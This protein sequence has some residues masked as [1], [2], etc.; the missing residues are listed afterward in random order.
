MRLSPGVGGTL[1][2][3]NCFLAVNEFLPFEVTRQLWLP[4]VH[5]PTAGDP[6]QPRIR[7]TR[8][9]RRAS[10]MLEFPHLCASALIV[11]SVNWCALTNRVLTLQEKMEEMHQ[12]K[13]AQ[14]IKSAEGSAGLLHKITKPT[15]W[16][17]QTQMLKKEEEDARLWDCCEAKREAWA[18]HWQCDESV[19]NVEDKPRE[20][21]ELKRLEEALPRLKGCDLEQVSRLYKAKTG[22]G[23]D[24]FHP[25]VPGF[26]KRN[27]RRSGG[28]LGGGTKWKMG[29]TKLAQR[30]SS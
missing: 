1:T 4:T 25:K 3:M 7:L 12:H 30:F 11:V 18:K 17:G 13:V 10:W 23:C 20:N 19:Q 26:D 9:V 28:I 6:D 16:K 8:T 5:D 29:A 2:H 27:K 22:V 21:E 24:G 15:A 14:M